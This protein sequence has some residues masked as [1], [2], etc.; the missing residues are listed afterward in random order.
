M[1]YNS[2]RSATAHKAFREEK[3]TSE[4]AVMDNY[5]KINSISHLDGSQAGKG[6]EIVSL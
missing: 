4:D 3:D 6:I 5:G 2:S 1:N